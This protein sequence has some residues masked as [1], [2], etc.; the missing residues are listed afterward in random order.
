MTNYEKIKAMSVKEMAEF[1]D[2]NC[3]CIICIHKDECKVDGTF[4]CTEGTKKW[5]EKEAEEDG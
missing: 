3:Q 1:L 4:D 5:L 2:F